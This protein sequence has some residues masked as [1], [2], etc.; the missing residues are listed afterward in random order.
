MATH[1][2]ELVKKFEA[3]TIKFEKGKIL[4]TDNTQEIDFESLKI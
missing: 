1:D 2:Y 4:E 3:R